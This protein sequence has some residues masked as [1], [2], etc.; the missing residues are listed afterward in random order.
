MDGFCAL[1]SSKLAAALVLETAEVLQ[2]SQGAYQDDDGGTGR[3]RAIHIDGIVK[4]VLKAV[5]EEKGRSTAATVRPS[6]EPASG[7]ASAGWGMISMTSTEP[8]KS[9]KLDTMVAVTSSE[10][11][12]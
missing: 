1:F 3:L 2:Q 5:H 6:A 9:A 7:A 4:S 12:S 11:A 8:F 10:L